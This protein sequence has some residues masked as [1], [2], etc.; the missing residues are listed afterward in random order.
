MRVSGSEG[1]PTSNK[2]KKRKKK[3]GVGVGRFRGVGE[4]RQFEG[5]ASH[6][7]GRL[8]G[9]K[10]VTVTWYFI[11][12]HILILSS[13]PLLPISAPH[14]LSLSCIELCLVLSFRWL[15]D[16]IPGKYR[17]SW[18]DR[19]ISRPLSDPAT[20]GDADPR[21]GLVNVWELDIPAVIMEGLPV[22]AAG[23]FAGVD[24]P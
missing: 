6:L 13:P 2:G 7:L 5:F 16:T 4:D 15:R 23:A 1:L 24:G 3:G 21:T 10:S 17:G 9:R 12:S 20:P 19:C 8:Q 11:S 22:C 14:H 18:P